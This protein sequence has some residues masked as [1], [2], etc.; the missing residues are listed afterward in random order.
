MSEGHIYPQELLE[1]LTVNEG[2]RFFKIVTKDVNI[3][4]FDEALKVVIK[5][6]NER[7]IRSD[8]SKLEEEMKSTKDP[9]K[10]RNLQRKM[11]SLYAV[12]KGKRG[13]LNG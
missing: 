11:L 10:Q 7:K 13:E 12:L 6:I 9:E 4:D 1:L 3:N 2:Q 5:K 8:I